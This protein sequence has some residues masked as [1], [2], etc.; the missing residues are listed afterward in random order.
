MFETYVSLNYSFP[1]QL[2]NEANGLDWTSTLLTKHILSP[3]L[4]ITNVS[5]PLDLVSAVR[6]RPVRQLLRVVM[7]HSC[8]LLL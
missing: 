8:H 2:R 6:I 7:Q 5:C 3:V 4:C 1:R